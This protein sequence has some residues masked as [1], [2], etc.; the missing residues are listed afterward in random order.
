MLSDWVTFGYALSGRMTFT[1]PPPMNKGSGSSSLI[2]L[3]T[4]LVSDV[5]SSGSEPPSERPQAIMIM[6]ARRLSCLSM[7]FS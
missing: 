6:P 1:S 4:A 2:N 7:P 5:C 3:E